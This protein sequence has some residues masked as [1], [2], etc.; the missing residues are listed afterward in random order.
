MKKNECYTQYDLK[1]IDAW[2][3]ETDGY[4]W[5]ASYTIEEA[6]FISD[7]ATLEDIKAL[8]IRAIFHEKEKADAYTVLE[9]DGDIY[10]LQ[11]KETGQPLYA[12]VPAC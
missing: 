3:N 6:I 9:Y 5:N 1:S 10:E 8:I 7:R 4:E 2:G 12:L 11:D